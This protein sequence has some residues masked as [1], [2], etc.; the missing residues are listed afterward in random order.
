MVE[1]HN[2]VAAYLLV[3]I[4]VFSLLIGIFLW[5]YSNGSRLALWESTTWYGLGLVS[6]CFGV[7]SLLV[8]GML[9]LSMAQ[10]I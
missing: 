2:D 6:T 9:W 8:A 10:I 7:S 4:G 1:V 3:L 5:R